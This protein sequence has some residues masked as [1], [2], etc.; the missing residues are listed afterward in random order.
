MPKTF[1]WFI[2]NLSTGPAVATKLTPSG[3]QNILGELNQNFPLVHVYRRTLA[4]PKKRAG[5]PG[6]YFGRKA[7]HL[8]AKNG[9]L[10]SLRLQ[11]TKSLK[12]QKNIQ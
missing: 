8:R 1:A 2:P 7:G 4:S 11:T 12:V 6:I 5:D 10:K 3:K 9:C